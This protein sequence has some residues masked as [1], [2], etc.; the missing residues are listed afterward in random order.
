MIFPPN[1][2]KYRPFGMQPPAPP[3]N[4]YVVKKVLTENM[5]FDFS[6]GTLRADT[7]RNTLPC[8]NTKFL[9]WWWGSQQSD[10][11]GKL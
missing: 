7:A 9:K 1:F 5:A 2:S 10:L 4:R 8:L 6:K 3:P 11:R